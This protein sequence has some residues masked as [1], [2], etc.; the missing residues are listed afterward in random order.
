M[1]EKDENAV[2]TDEYPETEEIV[3]AISPSTE[4][5]ETPE[6]TAPTQIAQPAPLVAQ[7]AAPVATA[8]SATPAPSEPNPWEKDW[9]KHA[10][11]TEAPAEAKGQAA[12]WEKNWQEP[13]K[14]DAPKEEDAGKKWAEEHPVLGRVASALHGAGELIPG[15]EKL[16]AGLH[17]LTEG[18]PGDFSEKY[19]RAKRAQERAGK[20]LSE[21]YPM[22]HFAGSI[23]PMLT[24]IGAETMLAGE[25]AVGRGIGKILP[26]LSPTARTMAGVS[27]FGGA[28][29]AAQGAAEGDT[30]DERLEGALTGAG[31][32]AALGPVGAGIGK[33]GRSIFG[34]L[35]K[36]ATQEAAEELGVKAP[37][38]VTSESPIQHMF[39]AHTQAIPI[40]GSKLTEATK[41]LNKQLGDK[42]LSIAGSTEPMH[43]V[44][45]E[46]IRSGINKWIGPESKKQIN[47]LYDDVASTFKNTDEK[48][49]LSETQKAYNNLYY[50]RDAANLEDIIS[51]TMS[52]V[53]KA[54]D[55]PDGL[56]FNGLQRLRQEVGDLMHNPQEIVS[57]KLKGAELK[58]L[59]AGLSED[60]KLAAE[61]QGG[62]E[63]LAAFKKAENEYKIANAKRSLLNKI[64]GSGDI[65]YSD[66]EIF[67]NLAQLARGRRG[68]ARR[69]ELAKETL[70]PNDWNHVTSNLIHHIGQTG[71][72]FSKEFSPAK[73]LTEYSKF[74][75]E[76][77]NAMFGPPGSGY[78]DNL[79]KIALLSKGIGEAGS[80][81]NTSKTAHVNETMKMLGKLGAIVGGGAVVGHQAGQDPSTIA[82]E[83]GGTLGTG[84]VLASLLAS[85][86]GTFAL[87]EWL[88]K[89]TPS[90]GKAITDEVARIT[91][92]APKA[93]KYGIQSRLTDNMGK[94]EERASGGKVGKRDYPAKRLTRLEKAAQRA[95]NQI[96]LE[97]KPL[98][99]QPDEQ[100]AHALEIASKTPGVL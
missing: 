50:E 36:T 14:K 40:V 32:G 58:R 54:I 10:K 30:A 88:D 48:N 3:E 59:Y 64:V 71:D 41:D 4:Q 43:K 11:Q 70:S 94:R 73:F 90:A 62:P 74:S 77:K 60:L 69:L 15:R 80:H 2:P 17:A 61:K 38:F 100:I 31:I 28:Y 47:E 84:W 96:A 42:I 99:D 29:G 87:R 57:R 35:G 51:P 98:L 20:A 7:P 33:V 37:R 16:S 12:P 86:R 44:A 9:S 1:S 93:I 83:I 27:G 63:G 97:T 89:A 19:E 75:P 78:R 53:K 65:R 55:N 68:D 18:G 8:P 92:H 23:A 25:G 82:G 81:L 6:A 22:T 24:P 76:G 66:E 34:P 39:G 21:A 67:D 52:I 95:H 45:G 79:D 85:P 26:S 5:V 49:T 46:K 13:E 56:T 91:G 72:E